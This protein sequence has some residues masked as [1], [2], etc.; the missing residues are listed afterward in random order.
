MVFGSILILVIFK[1][2]FSEIYRAFHILPQIYTAN[3][4]IFPIQKY[5]N[6]QY[7]FA[8]TEAPSTY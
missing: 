4:A 2:I 3:H 6:I 5:A 8:V 1:N 7:R